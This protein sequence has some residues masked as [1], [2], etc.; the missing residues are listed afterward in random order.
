LKAYKNEV[1]KSIEVFGEM[2]RYIPM[3]T[4]RQDLAK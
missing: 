1:V 3:L 2:H 4:K